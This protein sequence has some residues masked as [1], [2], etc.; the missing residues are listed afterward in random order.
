MTPVFELLWRAWLR[1]GH[2]A[3][4]DAVTTTLSQMCQ[5]GIFDHLAGGFSRYSTDRE[6][7]VPHFEKMLY[8]NAL[9]LDLLTLV[10]LETKDPLYAQRIEDIVRWSLRDMVTPSGGFASSFDAD[11]DHHEGRFAVWTK[12]EIVAVLAAEAPLFCEVYDVTDRG[13]WEGFNILNRS[14][15]PTLGSVEEEAHLASL[16]SRLFEARSHRPQ[17]G[18]DDKVLSD[19]NGLFISA[20]ARAGR[21][22]GRTDW[23][24]GARRAYGFIT[25]AMAD[26]DRLYH[27]WRAGRVGVFAFL[28]D[29][30]NM[31]QAALSLFEATGESS[32]LDRAVAWASTVDRHFWCT[33]GGGYFTTPDDGEALLVRSRTALDS[34]TPNGNAVMVGVLARLFHITGDTR[35]RDRADR[36]IA[37]FSG[38]LPRAS[39]GFASLV[40]QSELL[41]H[42]VSVTIYGEP[43]APLTEA[44]VQT[45]V[46]A[47]VPNL[48]VTVRPS[49]IG[50]PPEPLPI[51]Y[52]G[53]SSATLCWHQ[54]C[55]PGIE[56]PEILRDR[57]FHVKQTLC[58]ARKK[59][60]EA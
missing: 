14:H 54:R 25:T 49:T 13:N 12:A 38:D 50:T 10:W 26:N 37:A 55:E 9:L 44:M 40:N 41:D 56:T 35:Y 3:Y 8:D 19:W 58:L 60:G 51:G 15:C 52:K 5:G 36:I 27:S 7:L 24:S 43:N 42:A 21:A 30:A 48:M 16:R 57:L 32:F 4:H 18:W 11:S 31:C 34:A 59:G 33:D 39:L 6:W 2:P 23:V 28:E 1:T 17:P 22:F 53:T 20:L 47:S 29:Y 46:A 45:A